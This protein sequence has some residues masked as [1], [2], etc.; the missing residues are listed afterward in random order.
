MTETK[1][2]GKLVRLFFDWERPEIAEFRKAVEQFKTDL[3][4]VLQ[5]LRGKIDD[6]YASNAGFQEAAT[7][8]LMQAK[9]T[10]N[11]AVS[12]DDVRE[13]LIQHIL[14]EEI[15]THVFNEGDF[16]RDNNVAKSLYSLEG[17]FFTGA[18]KRTTLRALEPYYAAIRKNAAQITTHQEKQT[19]LKVIYEN[20][21]KVYNPKAADRLGVVYTPNE[22]VR[23]M[24]DGADWLTRKHFDGLLPHREEALD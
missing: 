10:I 6:A 16:H 8:F 19:F 14:T 18:V 11:P 9:Q 12:E 2:L 24:I 23:F 21:Y 5:A 17:K 3:P 7:S 13:M 1:D 4:A 20:F 15:F 22:I